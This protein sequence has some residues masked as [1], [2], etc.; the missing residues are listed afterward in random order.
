MI[1]PSLTIETLL[2]VEDKTRLDAQLSFISG[3][4]TDSI[5]DVLI[6]PE[7]TTSQ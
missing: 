7:I 6:Q 2:Q 1:F 3:D 5:T 4:D